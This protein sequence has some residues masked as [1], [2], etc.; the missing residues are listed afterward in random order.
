MFPLRDFLNRHGQKVELSTIFDDVRD[1][2][3][4]SSLPT[5]GTGILDHDPAN[6]V[7]V[8]K[9][10]NCGQF[11]IRQCG[12]DQDRSWRT[13]I[14]ILPDSIT[15]VLLLIRTGDERSGTT[16]LVASISSA[17]FKPGK[18]CQEDA[19]SVPDE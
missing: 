12:Y 9:A 2:L 17:T 15:A 14:V 8:F 13:D 18:I 16:V 1:L 3:P 11:E 19:H 7:A 4:S 5:S 10:A 6:G